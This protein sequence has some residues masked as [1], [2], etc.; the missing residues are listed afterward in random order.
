MFSIERV[1]LSKSKKTYIEMR[2]S[3]ILSQISIILGAIKFIQ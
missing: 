2:I 1:F 3:D